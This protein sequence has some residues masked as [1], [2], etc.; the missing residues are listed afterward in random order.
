M[1]TK[2]MLTILL[3]TRIVANSL[4]GFD[5]RS[6]TLWAL[7][8]F[9]CSNASISVRESEK[10]AASDPEAIA[11]SMRSITE[12]MPRAVIVK[13]SKLSRIIIAS[14]RRSLD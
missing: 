1:I 13:I 6:N 8:S 3:V 4:S 7:A 10:N 14:I 9:F 5:S 12:V 2:Q 11:E